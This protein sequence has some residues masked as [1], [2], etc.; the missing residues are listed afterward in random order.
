VA[1]RLDSSTLYTIGHGAVDIAT[2]AGYLRDAAI[3]ALVDIRRF[4]GSRRH[5]QFGSSAL[6]E[7]LHEIGIAY[8][9]AEDLG[10]RRHPSTGS[11]NSGLRNDG[12][13]GYADWMTSGAFREAFTN[14][15]S[16]L[17]DRRTTVMCAETP[18]WKCHRRLIADAS[19][20]LAN[21]PVVHLIGGKQSGH[22]LTE[23]VSVVGDRLLYRSAP[24][25]PAPADTSRILRRR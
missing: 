25:H 21:A 22:Q 1:S 10:G 16:E 6:S 3:E 17:R 18:W 7:A 8:R 14:L 19:V 4:P 5:P 20:L 15:M 11:P 2:F 13:R 9:H 24:A 12:F 23:G